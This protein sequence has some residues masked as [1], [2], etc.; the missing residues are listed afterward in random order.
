MAD[1]TRQFRDT[2]GPMSGA[3]HDERL[4]KAVD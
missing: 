4:F 3:L 2:L 1:R